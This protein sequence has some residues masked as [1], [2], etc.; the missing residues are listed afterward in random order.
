[1][2]MAWS[3]PLIPWIPRIA[4]MIEAS[5]YSLDK[6]ARMVFSTAGKH[7]FF[8]YYDKCQWSKDERFLLAL[9][10][11][12]LDRLPDGKDKADIGII[13]LEGNRAFRK[14]AETRAWNWQQG[15]RLQWL[16][17]DFNTRVIFNDFRD[18]KF[19]SVILNVLSVREERVFPFPVYDVRSDGKFAL[20][21]NFSRLD[22][23]REGYGY[24]GVKDLSLAE[25]KPGNDGIYSAD[26]EK[27]VTNLLFSI[28]E[29]TELQPMESMS[30]GKHWVDQPTF[31]PNGGKFAFLHRWQLRNK[32]MYSR[33]CVADFVGKK[34]AVL[35]D[36]GMA[37]HFAWKNNYE[38]LIWA[39][40][41]GTSASIG[42]T[43]LARKILVPI[44]HKIFR[45]SAALRQKISGD[46]FLF[47]KLDGELKDYSAKPTAIGW[48]IVKEDGHCSFS[49]DGKWLLTDTYPGEEHYRHL[50]LFNLSSQKLIEIGKFYSLPDK[51]YGVRDDWDLS[52]LR[53]DLHPRFDRGGTRI[54][55]DSVHE[56]SRQM[57][58]IE[59]SGNI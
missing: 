31:N 4:A 12:F 33:L 10:T 3:R 24:K 23:V 22:A 13:D 21:S 47:F 41:A 38:L 55:I 27:G 59:L 44:Y 16:G 25:E 17:P 35:L 52:N 19:V 37:S 1:M 39:R 40:P 32:G 43:G 30:E 54:C 9:E 57:Y 6:D 50:Q 20:Y 45:S 48:G 28:A 14:I 34:P 51:K 5:K 46:A 11:D 58:I 18:G 15:C 53:T 56:G 7:H 29:L 26:L 2:R 36:S 49:P 8:G 42:R